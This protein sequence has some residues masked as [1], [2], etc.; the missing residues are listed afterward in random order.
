MVKKVKNSVYVVFEYSITFQCLVFVFVL[1]W[2]QNLF[3]LMT[4]RM[5]DEYSIDDKMFQFLL[6]WRWFEPSIFDWF[7]VFEKRER[8]R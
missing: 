7:P 4:T 2:D 6:N 3:L 1:V 8:R 5:K